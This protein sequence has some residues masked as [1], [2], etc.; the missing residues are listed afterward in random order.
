MSL[1]LARAT[2]WGPLSLSLTWAGGCSQQSHVTAD[3]AVVGDQAADLA[4]TSEQT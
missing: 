2:T 4:L 3:A 1:A